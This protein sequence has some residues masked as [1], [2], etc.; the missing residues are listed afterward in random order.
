MKR[1]QTT[2]NPSI[3]LDFSFT[4]TQLT[5]VNFISAGNVYFTGAKAS[6]RGGS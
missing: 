6:A 1:F 3:D 4:M 5:P 2:G